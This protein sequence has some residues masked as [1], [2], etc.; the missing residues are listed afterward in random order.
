M[1]RPGEAAG[2]CPD[3]PGSQPTGLSS[4]K[5]TAHGHCCPALRLSLLRLPDSRHLGHPGGLESPSRLR[6]SHRGPQEAEWRMRDQP[7]EPPERGV[8]PGGA[9][10]LPES[11]SP[12]PTGP[13]E[14][15]LLRPA[16]LP[17]QG[18]PARLFPDPGE[19]CTD[20]SAAI[21][22]PS[23]SATACSSLG[24]HPPGASRRE[25]GSLLTILGVSIA[26]TVSQLILPTAYG[27]SA[28]MT[29]FLLRK[30][31]S[32]RDSVTA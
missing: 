26:L 15:E 25:G 13:R 27:A 22:A 8:C 3:S 12:P 5:S 24:K 16:L 29:P 21:I 28:V 14:A 1:S 23:L 32:L 17:L 20:S 19:P 11:G 10:G 2:C 4:A 6:A 7:K 18:A 9:L 31:K 30:W